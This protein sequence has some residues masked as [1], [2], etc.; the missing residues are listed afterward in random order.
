MRSQ[1]WLRLGEVPRRTLPLR[2]ASYAYGQAKALTSSSSEHVFPF[3][4]S[5][6]VR[7]M[8]LQTRD[9]LGAFLGSDELI[10]SN[11]ELVCEQEGICYAKSHLA[12]ALLRASG[13]PSESA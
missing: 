12:A 4:S 11:H 3:L 8:A 9:P 7:L 1:T 2:G 6:N 10:Q 13:V 5:W